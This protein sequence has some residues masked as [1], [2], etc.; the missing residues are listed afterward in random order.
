[1]AVENPWQLASMEKTKMVVFNSGEAEEPV[2]CS[3]HLCRL[4]GLEARHVLLDI[5][6][7]APESPDR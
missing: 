6:M 4:Q 5:I 2:P 3:G 1:M 7:A